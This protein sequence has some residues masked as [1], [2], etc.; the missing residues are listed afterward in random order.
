[1][2]LSRDRLLELLDKAHEGPVYRDKDWNLRALPQALAR[3]LQK[4]GLARTCQPQDPVNTDDDLADRFFQAG[5]D[6][7]VETGLLCSDT[8]RAITFGREELLAALA[9][10]PE[11][12]WLGEGEQRVHYRR[13]AVEDPTP[14]VWTA[15][16]SIAVSESLFVS[17]VEGIARLPVVDALQGPSL[18][19]VWGRPLR[20]GTPYEHLAGKYQAELMREGLRRAGREG[21]PVDAV[22]SSTTQYGVMGGLGVPGG[23]SSERDIVLILSLADLRTSYE[24]L[25]KLTHAFN[26]GAE[27]VS[28]GSW[29]MLGGYAGGPEGT[30]VACIANSLLLIAAFQASRGGVFPF[31][32]RYMGNSGRQGQWGLSV[33]MQALSRNTRAVIHAV[34]NQVAGP[35]TKMLL[36][37]S[38]VGM[39]NLAVSG[40]AHCT[41]TRSAGGRLTDYQ[42]PLEI[43]FAGEV[44]KAAAGM[45]RA[46]ANEIARRLIPLYEE[47]L[48]HPPDG[49]KFQECYDVERLQPTPEW[50]GIYDEVREEAAALG[51][52]LG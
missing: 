38:A 17:M 28:V 43:Q 16:L 34:L 30:A 49:S 26:C 46:Q 37:E 22:G 29:C 23:Y 12:F 13:R 36:Y 5:L 4:H 45:P 48:T 19:T 8:N 33:V 10:A 40:V 25:F 47:Q 6:V 9:Q 24:S 52:S 42:S 1:M 18:E 14:P 35:G 31:E 27:H 32:L 7:A 2:S 21:M 11:E 44:F 50:R 15:P 39:A 20:S 3:S 41:G 51:L